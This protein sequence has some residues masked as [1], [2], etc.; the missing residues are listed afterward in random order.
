MPR[1]AE[2]T[3]ARGPYAYQDDGIAW[4]KSLRNLP[5][6]PGHGYLADEPGLGKTRQLLLAAE[7]RT[8]VVAPALAL[9][10]G[11]WDDEHAKWRPDLDLTCVPYTSLCRMERVPSAKDPTKLVNHMTELLRPEY[12]GHWDTIIFDEAQYI[13][14][15]KTNWTIA[16]KK[17]HAD[18]VFLASGTPIPNWADEVFTALQLLR[19]TDATSGGLLG[20]YWR[21][22]AEWF[23][24]GSD[25]F[26]T[27]AILGPL[28][29]TDAGWARFFRENFGS[30]FL[31]RMRDDVLKD[32]PPLTET[33]LHLAMSPAQAKVY[34]QLKKDYIAWTED[35]HEISTFST[36]GLH[37]KLV[38]VATGLELL[39]PQAPTSPKFKHFEDRVRDQAQPSLAVGAFRM[40]ARVAYRCAQRV[41]KRPVL[42]IGGMSNRERKEAIDG[43]KDGKYDVLCATAFAIAESLTL[44]QAD[45]VHML[46]RT[47][48]PT[49]NL[50]VVRRVHRIGQTRPVSVIQYIT[51]K[52]VDS[53][54]LKTIGKK[55][56]QQVRALSAREFAGML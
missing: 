40:T 33:P 32:L 21:W 46:E 22:A 38:Q 25:G 50:Q 48:V 34:K 28:D 56:D 30:R 49:K 31:M 26:S 52:S 20:S 16:S 13:K 43:F 47:Y 51:E 19:P 17:L 36:G 39:D 4:L 12:K 8:L 24:I 11:V 9:S 53:A 41:G 45:T 35:G 15:R 18:Q 42:V 44:T 6:D 2:R 3:S 27:H 10:A 55:T 29:D 37:T 7:G 23:R 5:V 14:G 54:A 1:L